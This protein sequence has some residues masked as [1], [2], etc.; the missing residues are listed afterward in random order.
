MSMPAL[1]LPIY[2]Q[3]PLLEEKRGYSL[4]KKMLLSVRILFIFYSIFE[5][6]SNAVTKAAERRY[7][8]NNLN[9]LV[10]ILP[11]LYNVQQL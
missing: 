11:V 3:F 9:I 8:T 2:V 5:G 7:Q 1:L 6:L 10:I 4:A